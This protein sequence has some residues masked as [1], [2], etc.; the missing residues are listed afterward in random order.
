MIVN[1]EFDLQYENFNL[2]NNFWTISAW[3]LIFHMSI[4]CGKAFLSEPTFFTLW[5][6]RWTY[7]PKLQPLNFLRAMWI[8]ILD[9]NPRPIWQILIDWFI[10]WIEIS[11]VSAIIQPCNAADRYQN[12]MKIRM[13]QA[14][15][16]KQSFKFFSI[17]KC[18]LQKL[19]KYIKN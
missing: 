17:K 18:I 13:L 12:L 3:A 15:C 7:F 6:W 14:S 16:I 9:T 8:V 5:P 1:F 4:L 2:Y 19:L 11:A 10:Y